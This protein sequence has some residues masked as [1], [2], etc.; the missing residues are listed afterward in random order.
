MANRTQEVDVRKSLWAKVRDGLS[1]EERC[2]VLLSLIGRIEDGQEFGDGPET[3]LLDKDNRVR[4]ARV[5]Q[6]GA[7]LLFQ[8]PEV[9]RG[10]QEGIPVEPGP[11]QGWFTLGMLAY[12]VY[13]GADYYSDHQIRL[14]ESQE[15]LFGKRCVISPMEAARIPFGKAVSQLTAVEPGGRVQGLTAFLTYLSEQMPETANIR[16]IY[17]G[18][19]V[20]EEERILR[21][22]I[23]DLVPG[24][25]ITL[26][27]TVYRTAA[28][29]PVQ[30]PYRP[31]THRYDVEVTR[32]GAERNGPARRF[33]PR[34]A[35]EA[36]QKGTAGSSQASERWL[37]VKQSHLTG[38]LGLGEQMIRVF[39]LGSEDGEKRM[40]LYMQYPDSQLFLFRLSANGEKEHLKEIPVLK[41]SDPRMEFCVVELRYTAA[42]EDLWIAV[43]R[44]NDTFLRG[45]AMNL[46]DVR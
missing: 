11:E 25:T 5:R 26:S 30:S 46:R 1:E 4:I 34:R 2:D 23:E 28:S 6:G 31:G 36:A 3:I 27:G 39:K 7:E 37:Y 8:A 9:I 13:C 22:D 38:E 19:T 24:G 43:K 10:L 32:D 18:R 21:Q 20:Y 45:H 12:F 40:T 33:S 16:Y 14:L 17:A 15:H 44:Q 29:G 41:E 35:T 42:S